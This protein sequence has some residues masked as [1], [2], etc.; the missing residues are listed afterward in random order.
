MRVWDESG[1]GDGPFQF[2]KLAAK[3]DGVTI[4][5]ATSTK[6]P[7]LGIAGTPAADVLTVQG[8]ASM[9]ALKVD[10]SAVTQPVSGTF[11]QATQPV[12]AAALPLPTGSATAAKQPAIG[13][14][15]TASADVLTVQGIA[16]MTPLNVS[17]SISNIAVNQ[18]SVATSATLI[19]AARA[20][21]KSVMIMNEGAT[22]VR[23]GG[24]GVTTG[25]GVLLYGQKG[26]GLVL[27]GGAAIYGI[28]ASGSQS[29]SYL[30]AY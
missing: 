23:I 6:Q 22:D 4:D 10:G 17:E 14:A 25:T 9:T 28:V 12:S 8:A 5:P 1:I 29:V 24:S 3:S 11:W 27:D 19:V 21:R 7:A 15:G 13:T 30:E 16:S 26:S 20:G 2:V 18:V